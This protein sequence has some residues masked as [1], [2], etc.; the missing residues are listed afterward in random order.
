VVIPLTVVNYGNVAVP[1][2]CDAVPA[3]EKLKIIDEEA[4]EKKNSTGRVKMLQV[5]PTVYRYTLLNF[6]PEFL[7][8]RY[9]NYFKKRHFELFP[10]S[11]GFIALGR[12]RFFSEVGSG[13]GQNR[14][15][16]PTLL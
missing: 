12:L 3:S 15:E 11:G 4:L 1:Y 13:S 14:P 7:E 8:Y 16:P 6:V 5:L 2:H 10:K 9:R